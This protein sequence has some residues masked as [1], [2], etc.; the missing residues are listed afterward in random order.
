MDAKKVIKSFENCFL[1]RECGK[2][3]YKKQTKTSWENSCTDNL[4]LDVV[5]LLKEHHPMETAV[6]RGLDGNTYQRCKFCRVELVDKQ[7][8]CH[9]CGRKIIW[10]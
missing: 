4:Y 1:K 10:D 7:E 9:G 2:C 6:I 5:T 3:P 8:Y